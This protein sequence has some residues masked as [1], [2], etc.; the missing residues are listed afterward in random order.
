MHAGGGVVRAALLNGAHLRLARAVL[1]PEICDRL[2][3][4]PVRFVSFCESRLH[5]FL[6]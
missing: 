1:R 3:R 5:L 2:E 4:H 6:S